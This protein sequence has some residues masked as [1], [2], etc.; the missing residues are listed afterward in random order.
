MYKR[1]ILFQEYQNKNIVLVFI[2]DNKADSVKIYIKTK[3]QG[4][5]ISRSLSIKKENFDKLK[6]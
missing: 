4:K 1:Q 5:N 6:S 3:I 2:E